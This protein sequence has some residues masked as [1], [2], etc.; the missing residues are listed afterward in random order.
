MAPNFLLRSVKKASAIPANA[1]TLSAIVSPILS[2]STEFLARYLIVESACNL[3]SP[4]VIDVHG[5]LA[6]E[7]QNHVIEEQR[8]KREIGGTLQVL[9]CRDLRIDRMSAPAYRAAPAISRVETF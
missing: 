1:A 2:F 6:I 3:P 7:R 5:M 9:E 8:L 4:S